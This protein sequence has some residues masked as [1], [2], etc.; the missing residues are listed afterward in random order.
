VDFAAPVQA[1]IPGAQGRI[2]AVLA[3]TSAELNLRTLARLSGVSLAQASRVMPPLVELGIVERRDVPPAALFRLVE[4]HVAARAVLAV[5]RART[6]VLYELGA[7]A[8]QL[9]PPPLSVIVFGSL[10]QGTARATS[11]V[12]IVVIRPVTVDEDDQRWHGDLEEWRQ[13]ARQL[14]GNPI[15]L[16]EVAAA[17]AARLLRSRR[18]LWT[19][20]RQHGVVVHGQSLD[21]LKGRRSA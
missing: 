14:T 4:H 21:Q 12:D 15:E 5:A 10:A 17:A 18:P 7:T 20:I 19:D 11:D 16:V 8:G 9:S 2:L 6:T 13:H 1:L 3:R